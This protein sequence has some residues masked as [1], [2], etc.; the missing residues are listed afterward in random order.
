MENAVQFLQ[1][2]IEN[3]VDN[4]GAIEITSQEDDLGLLLMLKVAKE[5]M[6]RIIGKGGNTVQSIRTLLKLLGAKA[7]LRIN[8]KVTDPEE[9]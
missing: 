2:V 3:L 8:L 4:V 5:D 6:P 7:G 9:V 1:F